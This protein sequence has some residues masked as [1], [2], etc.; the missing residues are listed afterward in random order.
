MEQEKMKFAPCVMLVDAIALDSVVA[1]V[2]TYFA[3]VVGR[4]LPKADLA[5][6]LECLA[7]DAGW[8]PD[9]ARQVQVLLVYGNGRK[10]LMH[11]LPADLTN[12]LDG[13]AF[14]GELGEFSISAYQPSG[15]ATQEVLFTETLELLDEASEAKQW[16]LIPDMQEYS[17][18]WK[19]RLDKRQSKA[20][21]TLFAMMRP[22]KM[23]TVRF[24]QLGFAVLRALGIKAEEIK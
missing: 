12:E 17:T 6:L 1:D 8:L 2:A 22:P 4:K 16:I 10:R 9:A 20:E 18:T 23:G 24:E 7:L 19:K 13:K 21:C 14:K 3:P 11:C 15:M 5:V